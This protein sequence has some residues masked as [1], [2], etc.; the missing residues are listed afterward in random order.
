[1]VQTAAGGW[2]AARILPGAILNLP[3]WTCGQNA[4]KQAA[5][6]AKAASENLPDKEILPV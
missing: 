6:K 4:G 2:L 1:M 3:V 5:T